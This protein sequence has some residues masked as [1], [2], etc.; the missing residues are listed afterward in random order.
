[1]RKYKVMLLH[2]DR[3]EMVY[4]EVIGIRFRRLKDGTKFTRKLMLYD[5]EVNMRKQ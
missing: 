5:Y 4:N 1:M 2:D 3:T